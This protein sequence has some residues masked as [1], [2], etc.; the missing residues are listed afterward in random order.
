MRSRA[1]SFLSLFASLGTLICCALPAL[2][3]SLGMGAALAGLVSGFPGLIWIS[4]HKDWVFAVAGILLC[5]A[6]AAMFYS[7]D[8]SCPADRDLA[9]ACR[10]SRAVSG[11]VFVLSLAAYATGVF[12][13]Y[14]AP[15]L[16]S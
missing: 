5:A 13:A 10:S 9:R 14:I 4:E 3:V 11:V 7:R 1:L 8:L 16:N 12:F 6:G 15:L 2:L